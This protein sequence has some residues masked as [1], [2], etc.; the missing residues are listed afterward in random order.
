MKRVFLLVILLF[1]LTVT[2]EARQQITTECD[3]PLYAGSSNETVSSRDFHVFTLNDG[4]NH[5]LSS[6]YFLSTSFGYDENY[7]TV[8]TQINLFAAQTGEELLYPFFCNSI[9]KNNLNIN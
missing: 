4:V 3:A 5:E 7:L 2:V 1:V 9:N 8:S 6:H